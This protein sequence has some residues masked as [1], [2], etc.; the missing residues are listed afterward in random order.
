[1]KTKCTLA[2]ETVLV[3]P[4]AGMARIAG[5]VNTQ[6][7]PLPNQETTQQMRRILNGLLGTFILALLC[8][9]SATVARA[10]ISECPGIGDSEDI[11]MLRVTYLDITNSTST[12]LRADSESPNDPAH[13]KVKLKGWLYYPSGIVENR[14][15]IIFNHGHAQNR[16]EPCSVAK[17]FVGQGFVVFAP[18]RRGHKS[19]SNPIFRST[20]VYIDHFTDKC[21]RDPRNPPEPQYNVLPQLYF[22]SPYCRS[23]AGYFTHSR[24]AFEV[25]Y[26]RSQHEDVREQIRF[27][28]EHYGIAL[29]AS[30]LADPTRIAVLGHSW[31]GSLAIFANEYDYGQNVVIDISGA[32]L[33]WSTQDPFWEFDLKDAMT[34]QKSPMYFLQPKNGLSLAPTKVLFGKAVNKEY[35]SQA[36]IFPKAPWNPSKTGDDGLLVPEAKQ[37]HENFIGTRDQ[38]AIWGPSV[39]EFIERYPL[40]SASPTPE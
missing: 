16:P 5:T 23:D 6:Q 40:P 4:A 11:R 12:D 30:K 7:Q 14:P 13:N 36:A 15:I 24:N 35:R 29:Y 21:M 25:A 26:I 38:V 1:M 32:E 39:K 19:E 33:S 9:S 20:G 27:I 22:G 3:A 17:Y 18:L 34:A 37:A 31:G 2:N 28:K 10:D 8:L